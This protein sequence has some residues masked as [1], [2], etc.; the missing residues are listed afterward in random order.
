MRKPSRKLR[1]KHNPN[2]KRR[3]PDAKQKTTTR[4]AKQKIPTNPTKIPC[5]RS[6]KAKQKINRASSTKT[7]PLSPPPKQKRAKAKKEN[8]TT[9]ELQ[10]KAA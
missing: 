7:F 5:R 4:R 1:K 3:K 8:P 6:N 9:I 2:K 10:Q